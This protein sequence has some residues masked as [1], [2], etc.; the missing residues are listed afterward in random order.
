MCT[1]ERTAN[2][3]GGSR[4]L[5]LIG[6]L[7]VTVATNRCAVKIHYQKLWVV[8]YTVPQGLRAFRTQ[9]DHLLAGDATG[10]A[11]KLCCHWVHAG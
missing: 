3:T 6:K 8:V 4:L 11:T 2:S 9:E 1:I 7:V 5:H 10:M